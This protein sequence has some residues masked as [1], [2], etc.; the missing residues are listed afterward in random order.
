MRRSLAVLRSI[1]VAVC[2]AATQPALAAAIG[3]EGPPD[4]LGYRMQALPG[5]EVVDL[6]TFRGRPGVLFVFEPGCVWCRRQARLLNELPERCS[7]GAVQV[8]GV[9]IRGSRAA[10][11][12]EARTLHARF[13]VFEASPALAEN[14]GAATATP[15]L[16]VF[17]RD[18]RI[19]THARG[20]QRAEPLARLLTQAT[21]ANCAA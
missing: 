17:G 12:A 19:V 16:I 7:D 3:A 15:L 8:L 6:A 14:L 2:V 21:G 13:P 4:V 1:L 18:G 10:L 20:Y 9:G 5:S 11:L